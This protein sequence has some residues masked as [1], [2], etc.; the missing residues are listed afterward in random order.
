MLLEKSILEFVSNKDKV[1]KI[2]IIL[3]SRCHI[4]PS[5]TC[6]AKFVIKLIRFGRYT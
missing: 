5:L 3:I 1:K 6:N 4:L 2:L